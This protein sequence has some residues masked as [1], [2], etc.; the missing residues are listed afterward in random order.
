MLLTVFMNGVRCGVIEQDARG[1][2]TFVHDENYLSGPDPTPLSLS[3][4][5]ALRRHRKR[6]IVPFLDGLITDNATARR[7]IATRFG[8]SA[9]NPVALLSHIGAD[10]AGALQ[11]L[12]E[13]VDSPDVG[14]GAY[15]LLYES[16]VGGLLRGAIE[17]YRDGRSA[18]AGGRF[19][20]QAPSP[21]SR[22][23]GPS[24]DAGP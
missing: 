2:V 4:P 21:R 24:V 22:C 10:V 14:A 23:C 13:G 5:L 19:S 16:Q 15:R 1:G 9:H 11:I 17:E 7:A 20:L 6:A 3:M 8:V 18:G 12:P